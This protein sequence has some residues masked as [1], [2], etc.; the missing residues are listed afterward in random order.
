VLRGGGRDGPQ[1]VGYSRDEA[2][3][4]AALAEVTDGVPPLRQVL[5]RNSAVDWGGAGSAELQ[6]AAAIADLAS[7][8]MADP[9]ER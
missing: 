9:G 3:A 6:P 5:P 4:R 1:I 7:R 8:C 2:S